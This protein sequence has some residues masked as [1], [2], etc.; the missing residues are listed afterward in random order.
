MNPY[1]VQRGALVVLVGATLIAAESSTPSCAC[2]LP[3]IPFAPVGA[4]D[5]EHV[6]R[7]R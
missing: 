6:W 7:D 2:L 3:A 4:D 1:C 5:I